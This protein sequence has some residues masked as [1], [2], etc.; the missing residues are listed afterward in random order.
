MIKPRFVTAP[1]ICGQKTRS[2]TPPSP[3][4][5]G[6]PR[7]ASLTALG[8]RML[9]PGRNKKKPWHVAY[10]LLASVGAKVRPRIAL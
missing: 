9:D 10:L 1:G 3:P 8:A 6:G 7:T 5:S 2:L 4:P